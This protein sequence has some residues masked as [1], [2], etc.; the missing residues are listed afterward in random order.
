MTLT[1]R[2]STW[3]FGG[4]LLFGSTLWMH[5][6][7]YG[8]LKRRYSSSWWWSSSRLECCSWGDEKL[9]RPS[10]SQNGGWL[11]GCSVLEVFMI[12]PQRAKSDITFK[13]CIAP[14]KTLAHLWLYLPGQHP[15]YPVLWRCLIY[16]IFLPWCQETPLHERLWERGTQSNNSEMHNSN[17]YLGE[18]CDKNS[19]KGWCK[20]WSRRGCRLQISCE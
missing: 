4:G 19:S 10:Y 12:D 20:A 8:K 9:A 1:P 7:F 5:G 3:L 11:A 15:M 13:Y 14:Q 16:K 2:A 17:C 18:A 6:W